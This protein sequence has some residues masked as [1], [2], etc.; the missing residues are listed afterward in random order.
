MITLTAARNGLARENVRHVRQIDLAAVLLA[1][2]DR[3]DG[4]VDRRG[5]RLTLAEL[6]E[7]QLKDVGL[8]AADVARETAKPFWQG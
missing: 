2:L 7:A 5:Q 8:T 4:W 1:A 3:I 6:T